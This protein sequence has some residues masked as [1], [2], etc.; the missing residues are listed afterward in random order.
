MKRII[1]ALLVLSLAFTVKAQKIPE[2]KADKPH[3]M[4]RKKQHHK[5]DMQKLNLTEGQK[6]KFKSQNESFRKQME[7]LKKNENIT[8]KEWKSKM[9]G[10]R[11]QHKNN[12][13]G[14]LTGDQKAQLEK[15]K[16]EGKVKHEALTKERAEK[17][18]VHLGLTDEQSAKM[19]S[20]RKE[21]GGKMKAIR[22]NKSLSEE[23][24][25]EE[26]KELHKMQKENMKSVLTED[27][28]K[29]LKE[30]KHHKPGGERRKTEMK[31]PV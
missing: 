26:M 19:E 9:E 4:E 17:M 13:A 28:L 30:T 2:R 14:I 23:Q 31:Q 21:M 16:V 12:V 1:F 15:M 27:Q 25:R 3:M 24:K 7:E 22:D 6:S 5:M 29:K 8:V 10:L 11:K 18:K 20:N